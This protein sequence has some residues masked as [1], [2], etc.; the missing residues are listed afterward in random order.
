MPMPIG[1]Y[2]NVG[3]V[4]RNDHSNQPY[5]IHMVDRVSN[6]VELYTIHAKPFVPR[7]I[8][9]FPALKLSYSPVQINMWSNYVYGP[10]DP[11]I[12]T[13]PMG[14]APPKPPA[15]ATC[16]CGNTNEWATPTDDYV[17]Y[18]CRSYK[19]MGGYD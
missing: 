17:C 13:Q 11:A 7:R 3:D 18:D 1:Y 15:I 5:M 16:K 19:K 6:V 14:L 12:D 9:G 4:L 10:V 8:V 2:P